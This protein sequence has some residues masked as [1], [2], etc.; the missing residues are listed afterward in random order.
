[1]CFI[2]EWVGFA[3]IVDPH[4][5][6]PQVKIDKPMHYMSLLLHRGRIAL[7]LVP[8]NQIVV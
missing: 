6:K 7:G 8:E 4:V 1:M 2:L 5:G 3:R